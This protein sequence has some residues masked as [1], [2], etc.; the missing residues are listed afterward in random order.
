MEYSPRF[1]DAAPADFYMMPQLKLALRVWNFWDATYIITNAT[2]ELKRLL[3]NGFQEYFQHL[4]SRCQKCIVA[5]G[6]YF[7]ENVT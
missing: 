5:Q 1:P 2:D 3:H 7:E 6:D 4:Y